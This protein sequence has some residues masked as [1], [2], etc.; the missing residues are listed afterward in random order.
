MK[1]YGTDP[2]HQHARLSNG[3][4]RIKAYKVL[5]GRDCNVF[6]AQRGTPGELQLTFCD[7]NESTLC[8]LNLSTGE[9]LEL[10]SML[11][12]AAE[13][14]K[15]DEGDEIPA[16]VRWNFLK[17]GIDE[18]TGEPIFYNVPAAEY[19]VE[20]LVALKDG[21]VSTDLYDTDSATFDNF[22]FEDILAWA[23]FPKAPK[24]ET[25]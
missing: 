22:Y 2:L 16:L 25:K 6:I 14:A 7:D 3:C 20:V 9:A 13:S 5:G 23:Y 19:D 10:A 12:S 8:E 11:E 21:T 17:P 24:G 18:E 15:N 1:I 4:A